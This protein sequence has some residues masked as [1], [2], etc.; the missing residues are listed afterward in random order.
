MQ[1]ESQ[2]WKDTFDLCSSIWI[3][4]TGC[5]TLSR[6]V[7][8]KIVPICW[9][10]R[11][12]CLCHALGALESSLPG[13]ELGPYDL[14][15]HICHNWEWACIV[16]LHIL[17]EGSYHWVKHSPGQPLVWRLTRP[18]FISSLSCCTGNSWG[19]TMSTC[20]LL[21]LRAGFCK[22]FLLWTR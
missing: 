20:L 2:I 7:Q 9:W 1:K 19:Q 8:F 6:V 13:W 12:V 4:P 16:C 15:C 18:S 14:I 3:L 21:S 11:S 10:G 17:A 5:Q 22:L